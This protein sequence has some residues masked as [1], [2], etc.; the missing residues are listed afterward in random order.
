MKF[1][2]EL[3]WVFAGFVGWI[4]FFIQRAR[5]RQMAR[6]VKRQNEL[7]RELNGLNDRLAEVSAY[8]RRAAWF[9]CFCVWLI[10]AVAAYRRWKN[11]P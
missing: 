10:A 8:Y 4:L 2:I 5:A 9:G 6:I 3:L 7:L 1:N 11:K